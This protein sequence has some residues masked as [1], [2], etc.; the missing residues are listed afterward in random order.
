MVFLRLI[1]F[2]YH[3]Q[4]L[5]F[6]EQFSTPAMVELSTFDTPFGRWGMF[7]CFDI[8]F[9]EPAVT[10]IETKN[11][12]NVAFP[13]AWMDAL[14]LL[15]SVE[16]HSAFA[17]GMG[18]NFL[19]ANLHLPQW[20]F[21]G[22]GVY[23]PDG[24]AVFTHNRTAG[25]QSK[26]VVAEIDVISASGPKVY[27]SNSCSHSTDGSGVMHSSFSS[28]FDPSLMTTEAD[29]QNGSV[30]FQAELFH[31]RFSFVALRRP[32]DR[33]DVCH[34]SV[35]CHLNYSFSHNATRRPE[36]FAFGAFDGLHTF[37]GRYYLQICALVRCAGE[38]GEG[39]GQP[40]N[41]STTTFQFMSMTGAFQTDHVYPEVL[42]VD[43][44]NRLRLAEAASWSY[45]EH[46][47]LLSRTG[48]RYPVL[49]VSLFGRDYSRDR[50]SV[51][52]SVNQDVPVV[53]FS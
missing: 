14:P 16:F 8:L 36:L 39:C 18:V 35:C 43:S 7:T 27:S 15:A 20:S 51:G 19:A 42:L 50:G 2:R 28:R 17:R 21:Q 44:H 10:L 52:S 12:T 48:F 22:S 32:V 49:A 26:L 46:N 40:T 29:V 6:E 25:S 24:Q 34:G 1:F 5:F 13:T 11:V 23:T 31:D 30:V 9:K 38:S 53:W 37:N 3:K 47:H 33:L 41:S 45:T 4:N